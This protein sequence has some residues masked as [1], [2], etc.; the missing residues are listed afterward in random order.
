M[1]TKT[2]TITEE[3]YERLAMKKEINDSFSD[4]INKITG[5]TSIFDLVGILSS[6]E[7]DE[8]KTNIKELRKRAR[9]QVEKTV[10]ELQ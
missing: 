6:K 9:R 3:A 1:A 4:V 7:A 5:R 8:M 2:I 10:S